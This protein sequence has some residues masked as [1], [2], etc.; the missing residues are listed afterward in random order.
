[1]FS[2]SVRPIYSVAI[3]VLKSGLLGYWL[4]HNMLCLIYH[5][6]AHEVYTWHYK[7]KRRVFFLVLLTN[8]VVII[9]I[10]SIVKKWVCKHCQV[11]SAKKHILRKYIIII[12]CNREQD[13]TSHLCSVHRA[14]FAEALHTG[15]NVF[16]K[17]LS[18]LPMSLRPVTIICKLF[19][20][21]TI[22]HINIH[23]WLGNFP[24][25]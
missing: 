14:R 25:D 24:K 9:L 8:S 6:L 4:S 19:Q 23:V 13:K 10:T 7:K 20:L 15:T 21:S 22:I 17:Y 18:L 5:Y 2:N 1:M 12:I 16:T 11:S 3:Y